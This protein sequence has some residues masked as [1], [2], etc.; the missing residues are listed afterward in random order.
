[1]IYFLEI[2]L[3]LQSLSAL[4]KVDCFF[5]LSLALVSS[6]YR[7]SWPIWVFRLRPVCPSRPPLETGRLYFWADAPDTQQNGG[8]SQL[9]TQWDYSNNKQSS[10]LF[11][12][13]FFLK[14][15]LPPREIK[16]QENTN[17]REGRKQDQITRTR[18][19][20]LQRNW[21][22]IYF[23]QRNNK[24]CVCYTTLDKKNGFVCALCRG[25][26]A[27]INYLAVFFEG[28]CVDIFGFPFHLYRKF[29]CFFFLSMFLSLTYDQTPFYFSNILHPCPAVKNSCE[30]SSF[31]KL[32]LVYL[33]TNK[34][35]KRKKKDSRTSF[36]C[37]PPFVSYWNE[38]KE[39]DSK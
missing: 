15:F 38:R 32:G 9:Y 17:T 20:F 13:F 18:R 25:I 37:C 19:N 6:V 23:Q 7:D 28:K 33:F 11:F 1:M 35:W 21:G 14:S 3:R 8:G 16:Q 30:F 24:D 34:W 22:C 26:N 12:F 2:V 29:S 5:L 39:V 10:S 4:I 31:F 27:P 36:V